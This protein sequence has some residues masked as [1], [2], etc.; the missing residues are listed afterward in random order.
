M[1]IKSK[2]FVAGHKGLVGSAICRKLKAL[3]Y[4]NILTQD[5]SEC[6]LTNQNQVFEFFKINKPEYVFLA[7]AKVGGIQANNNYPA[8]FIYQNLLIQTNVIE[9][10]YKFKV[11]RLL[12]LGSSCIYPKSCPQPIKEEYLLTGP[13]EP[14]NRPYAIAKIAGIEQCWAYNR[15]YGTKFI[16]AM[17]TNVFGPNDNYDLETSHVLPALLKKVIDAK[18][19]NSSNIT[20]WGTGTPKRE[21]IYSDDLADA[22]VFILNLEDKI[23]NSLISESSAPLINIGTG[24]DI[25]I[26]DLL[27]LIKNIAC[28]NGEVIWDK[29]KPDGTL[30]KVMDVS[31]INNLGWEPKTS[32]RDGIE[33][34]LGS[35]N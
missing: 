6:D 2:I 32:L 1:D 35:L 9:A 28:F 5:R 19:N 21:F 25:S 12:F 20:A 11:N 18:N 8:D 3:G 10:S 29:T 7:A 14:T 16:A 13:L 33:K 26:K 23:Y 17:P 34:L 24:E 15:Q 27:E 22:C 31:K 4:K 30:R